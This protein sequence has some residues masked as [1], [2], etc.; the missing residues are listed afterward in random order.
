[1][2]RSPSFRIA[3]RIDVSGGL[4][5]GG[6]PRAEVRAVVAALPYH[7]FHRFLAESAARWALRHPLRPL[8]MLRW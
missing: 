4:V 5:R 3:D 6:L 8:P 1:M 7:G 2:I